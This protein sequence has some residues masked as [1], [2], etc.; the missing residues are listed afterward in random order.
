MTKPIGLSLADQ[1]NEYKQTHIKKLREEFLIICIEER[2]QESSKKA[3]RFYCL[4]RAI[5]ESFKRF[6]DPE[7]ALTET[8][9][10][11]I[12]Q[13]NALHLQDYEHPTQQKDVYLITG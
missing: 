2:T 4:A 6:E 7:V 3:E 1:V 11:K 9:F 10:K 8:I 13:L 5:A 12:V